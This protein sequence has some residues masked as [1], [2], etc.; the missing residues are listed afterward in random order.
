ML[1]FA[2]DCFL[3]GVAIT[4]I[5]ACIKPALRLDGHYSAGFVW[6]CLTFALCIFLLTRFVL[7]VF[8]I[9]S[10]WE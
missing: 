7:S 9:W 5:F 1:G 2:M 6:I 8:I 3:A 4:L 10:M